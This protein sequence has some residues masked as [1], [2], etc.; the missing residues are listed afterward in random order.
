MS[1]DCH[2]PTGSLCPNTLAMRYY[3]SGA[4]DKSFLDHAYQEKVAAALVVRRLLDTLA[5]EVTLQLEVVSVS[6]K[7]SK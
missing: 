3:Q 7:S 5:S 2:T 6:L 4:V 1:H